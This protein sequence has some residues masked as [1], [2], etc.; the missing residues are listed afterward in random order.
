MSGTKIL[1]SVT[2]AAFA[3]LT[4]LA[5]VNHG[6]LGF[7][8]LAT[9]NW[10]VRTLSADLV[11]CLSLIFVW[12]L[13]DARARGAAWLPYFLVTL[14]FGAAGPLLYLIRRPTAQSA[15]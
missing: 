10:A 8:Q 13:R 1:L 14:V 9:A 6:Y 11:I 7:F 4:T 3:A 5:I 2:L 15:S 12:M